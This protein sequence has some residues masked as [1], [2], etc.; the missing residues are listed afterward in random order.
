MSSIS[1]RLQK[2][3]TDHRGSRTLTA[4]Q[5]SSSNE[6]IAAAACSGTHGQLPGECP[7]DDDRPIDKKV[8]RGGQDEQLRSN[9]SAGRNRLVELSNRFSDWPTKIA[10]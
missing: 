6:P 1:P 2:P 7:I 4:C 5:C 3:T 9:A 10:A 8:R